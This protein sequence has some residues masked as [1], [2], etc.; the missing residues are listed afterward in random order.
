METFFFFC[1]CDGMFGE[2]KMKAFCVNP[3]RN[4]IIR[5]FKL[6]IFSELMN[7]NH[8]QSLA[9][10]LLLVRWNKLYHYGYY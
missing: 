2:D 10:N 9:A 7:Q 4:E 8:E 5:F 6:E 3:L 1:S